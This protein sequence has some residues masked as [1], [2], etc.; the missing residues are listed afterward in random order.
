MYLIREPQ[1]KII[2]SI[3][4]SD[5]TANIMIC[6]PIENTAK[7]G[8]NNL[9]TACKVRLLSRHRREWIICLFNGHT[10][11]SYS[12]MHLSNLF[13]KGSYSDSSSDVVLSV[14]CFG[15]SFCSLSPVFLDDMSRIMR[16]PASCICENKDADELGEASLFSLQRKYNPY[17]F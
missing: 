8:H 2:F 5:R 1:G 10:C 16:K 3:E 17:T 9:I 4:L 14:A 11:H 6:A 15:V 13:M 7:P 12:V